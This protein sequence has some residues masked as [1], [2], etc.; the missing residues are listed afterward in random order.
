MA[1]RYAGR[2]MIHDVKV[3]DIMEQ[4]NKIDEEHL[5][6]FTVADTIHS[7]M[8]YMLLERIENRIGNSRCYEDNSYYEGVIDALMAAGIITKEQ[9][10]KITEIKREWWER[11]S[12]NIEKGGEN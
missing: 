8:E 4:V 2:L 1:T 10:Q 6:N 7:A 9:K 5:I 3:F 11:I 12:E